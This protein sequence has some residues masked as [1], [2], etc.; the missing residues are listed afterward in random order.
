MAQVQTLLR[1]RLG[2]LEF[3]A[4][5]RGLGS[6]ASYSARVPR[7]SG[8]GYCPAGPA[9]LIIP[10]DDVRWPLPLLAKVGGRWREFAVRSATDR[11]PGPHAQNTCRAI[12]NLG[13]FVYQ[14]WT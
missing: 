14:L 7:P 13:E 12:R 9:G 10:C 6:R 1:R 4:P 3:C 11:A 8:L 2:F 5:L